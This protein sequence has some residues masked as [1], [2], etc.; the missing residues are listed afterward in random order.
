V[1]DDERIAVARDALARLT[2]QLDAIEDSLGGKRPGVRAD[3]VYTRPPRPT[4]RSR[5]A[6]PP[7]GYFH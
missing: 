7:L 4:T 5:P 6:L 2:R 1:T 3:A